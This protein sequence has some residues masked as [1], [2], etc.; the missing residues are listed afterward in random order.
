MLPNLLPM[1]TRSDVKQA[2]NIRVRKWLKSPKKYGTSCTLRHLYHVSIYVG[3]TFLERR[4]KTLHL[5][6]KASKPV[7]Q[8]RK[9]VKRDIFESPME[10]QKRLEEQNAQK[11]EVKREE[12]E[13]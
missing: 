11:E 13:A 5:L 9:R 6:K 10:F 4:G 3:L 8:H 12:P 7:P 2:Q 1:P